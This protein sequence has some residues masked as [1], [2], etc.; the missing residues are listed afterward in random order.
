[1]NPPQEKI[2]IVDDEMSVR[3]I[4]KR[5]LSAD[6][7]HCEEADNAYRALDGLTAGAVDLVVLDVRMPG[8]SGIELLSEIKTI[9]PGIAVIMVTAATDIDTAVCCL[10]A[11]ADDYLTKPFDLDE[12]SLSVER[13]LEQ[14]RLKSERK[15]L[16]QQAQEINRLATLAEMA[17]GIAHEVNNP[18][19]AIVNYAELILE[20]PGS[21]DVVELAEVIKESA[22]RAATILD[23]LSTF[24]RQRSPE[25]VY[26]D[27]NA[28]LETTLALRAYQLEKRAIRVSTALAP[29]LPRILA[30]AG[31]LQQVFINIIINAEYFMTEAHGRG[32][33]TI[34]TEHAGNSVRISFADDGPGIPQDILERVFDPFFTTREVGRGVGLGLSICYGI[35]TEHGGRIWAESEE[36]KGTTIII[37]LPLSQDAVK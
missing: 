26:L 5:K 7:Y 20:N 13:A 31:Q 8:K 25:R 27:V 29:S 35:V 10:R 4:L 24:A 17:G 28:V 23:N 34:T 18:L 36:G 16:E 22:Q 37:E 1:M 9:S 21:G 32:T 11:G 19:A 12:I 2:L 6:G 3:R 33:L 15:R 30:N 14:R